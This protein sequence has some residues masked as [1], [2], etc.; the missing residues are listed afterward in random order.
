MK[1]ENLFTKPKIIAIAGDV[2]QGKSMLLYHI[3]DR[4]MQKYT[5]NLYY[6]GLH[7]NIPDAVQVFSI[8]ELENVKNSIIIIDE[9]SSLFDLDNRKNKKIIE[10]SFRL[11]NHNNNIVLLCGTPENFKKFLSAKVDEIIFKQVT[12][13]DCVNGS[14]LKDVLIRYRGKERGSE[15]LSLPKNKAL[16]WDGKHY[17]IIDVPYYEK[18]DTK[19]QNPDILVRKNVSENVQKTCEKSV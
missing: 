17:H 5:F 15:V 14:R 8:A 19:A 4:A 18:Y 16:R 6:Y 9:L 13:A 3:L 7:I 11:I 12:I 1:K 10:N 2:N